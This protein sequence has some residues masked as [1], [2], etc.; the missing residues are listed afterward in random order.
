MQKRGEQ[1]G[2]RHGTFSAL[3]LNYVIFK[4]GFTIG[5]FKFIYIYFQH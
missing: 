4:V 3:P 5:K 2:N 1:I